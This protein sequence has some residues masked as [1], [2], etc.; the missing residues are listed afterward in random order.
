MFS[1]VCTHALVSAEPM[2][3]SARLVRF[4]SLSARL[5]ASS[6]S[7]WGVS[8]NIL[9]NVASDMAVAVTGKRR[10]TVNSSAWNNYAGMA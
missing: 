2:M 9:F 1:K 5:T 7:L 4:I 8:E 6:F 10:F 3:A